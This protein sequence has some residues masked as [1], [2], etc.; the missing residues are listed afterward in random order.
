VENGSAPFRVGWV[1][2]DTTFT[3]KN[4]Q[5]GDAD[6][7]I[8]YSPAAEKIAADQGIIDEDIRFLFRDHFL[9]VGPHENP[10]KVDNSSDALT[11]VAKIFQSA[12]KNSANTT[13]PTRWLSRYDKS[14]TNIKESSL[15]L[16]IGQVCIE[17]YPR[18]LQALTKCNQV[19]WATP[20]STWYHQYIAFPVQALTTAIQLKEYTLTDRGTILSLPPDVAK[21]TTIYKASSDDLDDILL[22]PAHLLVGKKAQNSNMAYQFVDWATGCKGQKVITDFRKNGEQLYTGAP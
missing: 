22:N 19:P 5:S 6:V 10:A 11:I 18:V 1:L 7:G 15:W 21:Q 2:S 12:D 14:A 16:G 9:I 3:I 4:L 13:L 20:Y 8:T 17:S